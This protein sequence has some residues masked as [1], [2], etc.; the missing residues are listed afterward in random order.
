MAVVYEANQLGL[1]R[2]VALKMGLAGPRPT[3]DHSPPI[4]DRGRGRR[5]H[6]TIRI[7][8][9]STRS[10]KSAGRPYFSMA[11]VEGGTLAQEL[12]GGPVSTRKAAQITETLA[13]AI[14]YAHE[15]GIIHR[16]LKPA[17]VL[18]TPDGVPKIA[19]FGLAKHLGKE[20]L[21]TQTGTILG[22]PC[23]MSPEQ[24]SGNVREAGPT[25]DV[26][27]LGAIL[28]EMLVGVP[29]FWAETPLETLRKLLNEEPG[30]PTRLRPKI[31]CDLET[32]CLKCLEKSPHAATARRSSWPRT[33]TGS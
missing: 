25:S 22:S 28:Y 16:D 1:N 26:Y 33:S 31:P 27:S 9:R 3:S 4:P 23:Y 32:I 2:R 8:S 7:S 12:A 17:N 6:S 24:A 5:R 15:R 13:R 10:A 11:M 29:P 14:H 30:R 20:S 21:H 19:D 18:L